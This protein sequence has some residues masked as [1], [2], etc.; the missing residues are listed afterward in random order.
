MPSDYHST[1]PSASASPKASQAPSS[2]DAATWLNEHN[3]KRAQYG[4]PA[5]AWSTNLESS[6]QSYANT[7]A[8]GC[9]FSHSGGNYGTTAHAHVRNRTSE[10]AHEM[11]P[12]QWS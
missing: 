1:S 11:E 5:L 6:A 3:A 9:T 2:G 4:V 7:L 8:A 10:T 12:N